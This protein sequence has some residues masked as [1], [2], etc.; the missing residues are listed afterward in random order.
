[1]DDSA[2]NRVNSH[3]RLF[4]QEFVIPERRGRWLE[5]LGSTK[6]RRSFLTRLADSRDF[7][8]EYM[9]PISPNR[10]QVGSIVAILQNLGAPNDCH[11]ISQIAE[12]DG[13]DLA[14]NECLEIV[15]GAGLGSVLSCLPGQLAYYEEETPGKRFILSSK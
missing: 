10:H 3:E 5:A 15:I 11:A 4:I 7:V 8:F 1:M 6:R 12:V 13:L 14:L 2:T 9:H